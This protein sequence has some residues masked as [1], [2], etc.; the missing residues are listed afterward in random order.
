MRNYYFMVKLSGC[1]FDSD[2]ANKT[3][4]RDGG[5]QIDLEDGAG[6]FFYS[7]SSSPSP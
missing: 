4:K 1:W 3:V 7:Q 5:T 6:G 2:L